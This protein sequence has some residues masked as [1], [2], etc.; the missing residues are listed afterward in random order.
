MGIEDNFLNKG[1]TIDK[2]P[3]GEKFERLSP[4]KE[5]QDK[6][7]S[8][9]LELGRLRLELADLERAKKD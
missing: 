2:P 6:I 1:D 7:R 4:V 8:M 5:L 3:I 9:E